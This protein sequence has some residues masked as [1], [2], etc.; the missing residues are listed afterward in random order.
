MYKSTNRFMIGSRRAPGSQKGAPSSPK[1]P[2]NKLRRKSRSAILA[3]H[4]IL[5]RKQAEQLRNLKEQQ[6]SIVE[7]RARAALRA[8]I[9]ASEEEHK[10]LQFGAELH[11]PEVRKVE[12]QAAKERNGAGKEVVVVRRRDGRET[13]LRTS[14][15][16]RKPKPAPRDHK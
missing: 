14:S 5:I 11:K 7:K 1:E 2:A 13:T 6:R 12:R 9:V 15:G 3:E 16:G 8:A 4:K 10:R